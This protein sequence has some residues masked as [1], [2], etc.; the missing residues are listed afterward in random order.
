VP[1]R[2]ARTGPR[3]GLLR[4]ALLVAGKD[5]R[6]EWAS[7]EILYTMGFLALLVVLIFAF[8][9]LSGAA[10]EMARPD[11]AELARTRTLRIEFGPGVVS[12]IIWVAVLFS[13]TVALARTFDR[14][15]E[16]EAIRSLLLSPV[17]RP[18]IYLGKVAATV[19]LMLAVQV[20]MVPLTG[21]FF[22]ASIFPNAPRLALLLFLG[23]VG[24][25]AAGTIFSAALLRSRSRDVLL[26][27]LLY[28]VLVPLLLAGARG[29][30]TVLDPLAEAGPIL[31]WTQ[32]LAV[33][34]VIFLIIGYWAFEPVATGE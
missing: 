8:A 31:F 19:V 13:G 4:Q 29:T 14:E 5:L 9:F 33:L 21:L 25:A 26:S 7:R 20:L 28:P 6:I 10:N 16:G 34:D 23:S 2:K 15:R 27:A 1:E 30:A 3:A 12:G 17:P 24:F 11:L 18:A 22:S 32:F